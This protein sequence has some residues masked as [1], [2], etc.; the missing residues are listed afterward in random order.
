MSIKQAAKRRY[1][2]ISW[3]H[4]AVRVALPAVDAAD[5]LVRH[6]RGL[7]HVTAYSARI[8]STGMQGEFG[9][10]KFAAGGELIA[11]QLKELAGLTASDLVLEIGCGSGRLALPMARQLADGG[12]VGLD[13]DPVQI[14]ACRANKVLADCRFRFLLADIDSDLYNPQGLESAATYRLPFEDASFDLV[15][16]YSVFTHMYP[17]ECA[18]FAQEIM[19]VL[20][21]GGRCTVTALLR[22]H[23]DGEID[24]NHREDD[25]WIAYPN[26]PRKAIGYDTAT[27]DSWFGVPYTTLRRGAWHAPGETQYWQDW[28]LYCRS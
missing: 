15:F 1:S 8:R 24:F 3:Q 13:I 26:S 17:P 21:P 28:L 11:A 2:G 6:V 22:D 7:S 27:V 20:R 16:L 12:Y 23:G 14:S 5:A 18:N 10:H 9:G 25:A 4:P 19:R